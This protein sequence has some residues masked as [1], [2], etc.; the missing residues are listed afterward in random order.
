[1]EYLRYGLW[2]LAV[3]LQLAASVYMF[4]ERL[5]KAFPVFF[6]YTVFQVLRSATL[7]VI[8]QLLAHR[9]AS[10]AL[11]FK[12]YWITDAVS[13]GLCLFLVFEIC[14]NFLR[15]YQLARQI[16]SA[17]LVIGAIGLLVCDI[18]LVRAVPGNEKHQLISMILLL[19]RSVAFIQ[20]GLVFIL[21]LSA[22]FLAIPWRTNLPFGI[23]FGL[24]LL[25]IASLVADFVRVQYGESTNVI[26]DLSKMFTYVLAA[27]IWLMYI[28]P[29]R[30]SEFS[31]DVKEVSVDP[32]NWNKILTEIVRR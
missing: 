19:D 12:F 15:D 8:L 1:M 24:G 18:L 27:L 31:A 5:Y 17:C 30:K 32:E 3:I 6:C 4:K 21:F 9:H 22:K 23:S 20:A 7:F 13:L 28:F 14:R 16:V 10:Y 29:A 2:A 11:Y 25:G 26:Y